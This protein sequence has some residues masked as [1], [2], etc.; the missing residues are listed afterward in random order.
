MK[1]E[2]I[3]IKR[4]GECVCV[5]RQNLK[6]CMK[7]VL[8]AYCRQ[9]ENWTPITLALKD[10]A[11]AWNVYQPHFHTADFR[12]DFI[13]LLRAIKPVYEIRETCNNV[14]ETRSTYNISVGKLQGEMPLGWINVYVG[15]WY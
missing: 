1:I 14:Y 7:R 4:I 10:G 8:R 6:W 5:H 11:S 3:D 9:C 2:S 13:A 12:E 15:G